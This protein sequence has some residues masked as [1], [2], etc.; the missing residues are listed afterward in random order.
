MIFQGNVDHDLLVSGSVGDVREATER[1]LREG[2][3]RRHVLNLNHG[4]DRRTPVA[5]FAEFVRTSVAIRVAW[6]QAVRA[7]QAGMD[8]KTLEDPQALLAALRRAA[9]NPPRP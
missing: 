2:G 3:G 4:V 6:L 5:N 7:A 8:Q 1:C 9:G